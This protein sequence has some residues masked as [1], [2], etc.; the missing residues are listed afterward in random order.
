MLTALATFAV[1][2][3]LLVLLPGPDTLVVLRGLIRGG[4]RGAAL[5][6]LGVLC[7]VLV[8]VCVAALG[9]AALL[10]AS[11]LGYEVLKV[12]GGCYLVWVGVGSLRAA[13][14][15]HQA[16]QP[17][18]VAPRVLGHSG[19]VA[20]FLT[21][22]LNPKVGVMFVTFLPA[23]VP[24]GYPVGWASM[25]LGLEFVVVTAVYF[26]VFIALSSTVLTWMGTPRI[27]R[28]LDALTGL[29]LIGFGI[30]LAT[31]A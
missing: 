20:G 10:R 17:V 5:T 26:T 8:W 16:E 6:V 12:V 18:T 27:R 14:R 23:F 24:E 25:A 1:P 31:E 28:R 9:L 30:R 2:C 4:R 21:D 15:P 13:W 11:E 29:V 3:V 22:V 19:F 7:G